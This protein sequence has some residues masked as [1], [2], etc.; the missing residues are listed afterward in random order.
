[1]LKALATVEQYKRYNRISEN[2]NGVASKG[3]N[4]VNKESDEE[5]T[6][7]L[8]AASATIREYTNRLFTNA[9][10]TEL[11]MN[12]IG[13]VLITSEDIKSI[14]EITNNSYNID[15]DNITFYGNT[16][17]SNFI[18]SGTS[19][20][21]YDNDFT[22]VPADITQSCIQL[23]SLMSRK[24]DRIGEYSVTNGDNTTTYLNVDLPPDVR[25]ILDNYVNYFST[26]RVIKVE[27]IL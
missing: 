26:S 17:T 24:K 7:Y 23:A 25:F 1:M 19:L 15:N 22:E 9:K 18:L 12:E 2:Q 13:N 10:V 11:F 16:I 14:S 21:V 4:V 3:F 6:L 27:E 20:V 8:N 5:I